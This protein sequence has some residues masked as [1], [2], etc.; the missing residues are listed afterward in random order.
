MNEYLI[1]LVFFVLIAGSIVFHAYSDAI[2]D[3]TKKRNHYTA[4]L[5]IAFFLGMTTFMYYTMLSPVIV[6]L[7]YIFLRIGIFNM[8]YNKVRGLDSGYIG[9]TDDIFDKWMGKLQNRK[10]R[11]GKLLGGMLVNVIIFGSIIVSVMTILWDVY[12]Y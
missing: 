9:T 12:S 2:L 10:S 5:M 3:K 4:A 1:R 6:V 8:I 7:T 11:I